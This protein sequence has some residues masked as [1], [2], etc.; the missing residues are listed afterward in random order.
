M[1]LILVLVLDL[2]SFQLIIES[3][4]FGLVFTLNGSHL[5]FDQTEVVV[6]DLSSLVEVSECFLVH[7]VKPVF[8][9]CN[10][11]YVQ[12]VVVFEQFDCIKLTFK[13]ARH[14]VNCSEKFGFGGSGV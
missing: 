9:A 13:L 6:V 4:E 2:E 5:A 3:A 14:L 12:L 8:Q 7:E 11:V 1:S 10:I